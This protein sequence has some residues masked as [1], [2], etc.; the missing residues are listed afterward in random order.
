MRFYGTRE[1]K[2]GLL[3][4]LHVS[5][6]MNGLRSIKNG[7]LGLV[8]REG[9]VLGVVF[10]IGQGEQGILQNHREIDRDLGLVMAAAAKKERREGLPRRVAVGRREEWGV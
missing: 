4:F 2:M 6:W 3:R 1:Q 5:V 10:F 9:F 8:M 7:F